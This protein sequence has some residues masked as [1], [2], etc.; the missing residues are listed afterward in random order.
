MVRR[1]TTDH[2]RHVRKEEKKRKNVRAIKKKRVARTSSMLVE[3]H[4]KGETATSDPKQKATGSALSRAFAAGCSRV[5]VL[6]MPG[7]QELVYDFC[8]RWCAC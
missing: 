2:R 7:F 8:R 6:G 4:D 5:W 3:G 1:S